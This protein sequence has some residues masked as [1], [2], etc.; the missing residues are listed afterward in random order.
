MM[1][2]TQLLGV[3]SVW[4]HTSTVSLVLWQTVTFL[5]IKNVFWVDNDIC[6]NQCTIQTRSKMYLC[7]GIQYETYYFWWRWRKAIW[8]KRST[9]VLEK[10]IFAF[11][12]HW[13]DE[14]FFLV[15]FVTW[16]TWSVGPELNSFIFNDMFW[17]GFDLFQPFLTVTLDVWECCRIPTGW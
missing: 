10:V 13:D 5:S 1:L 6:L 15:G 8:R 3:E 7:F 16:W 17:F 12:L 11:H 2:L 14:M 9:F 4:L